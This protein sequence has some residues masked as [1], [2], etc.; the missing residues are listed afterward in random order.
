MLKLLIITPL[1]HIK[2]V[3]DKLESIGDVTYMD[4]PSVNEIFSVVNEYDAIF[5]NPNKSKVYLG[6]ELIDAAKNLKV[7]CTASTG[8]NHID[9]NYAENNGIKVISIKEER[10]IIN[11]ISS[12][13]E[14]AFTLMLSSLRKINQAYFSVLNNEWDYLPFIGKQINFL[15]IGVIGYGRLGK[16][17][18]KYS[19]GFG[20]KVYVFDPYQSVNNKK[21]TQISS[22]KEFLSK[23]DVISIHV[24][25]TKE[26]IGMINK[27]AFMSM[28]ND[29]LIVNT[30]RGDVIDE[31]D[32]VNFLKENS[33]AC[34]AT[35]VLADEVNDKQNS[36]LLKY[37]KKS[38]QVLITPHIGGMTSHAQEIA[39]NHSAT[40]LKKALIKI[41]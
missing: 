30:S 4:D 22:F 39:Y 16:M 32:S 18:A 13:A 7:I 21:Y 25:I 37:A 29:V 34:I 11:K 6:K 1:K 33:R 15:N 14:L 20:A 12:T 10:E 2:G 27:Y 35:D 23:C 3:T 26:T 8:T 24:H 41:K 40:L 38:N 19:S 5:T 17:F 36:K 31:N 28:K 9:L